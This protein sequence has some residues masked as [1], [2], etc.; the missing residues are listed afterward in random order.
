M[1]GYTEQVH[2]TSVQ[3]AGVAGAAQS[4]AVDGHT[5]DRGVP[6]GPDG[7]EVVGEPGGQDRLQRVGSTALIPRRMVA[8]LG[9][10]TCPVNGPGRAPSRGSTRRGAD[11]AEGPDR[12]RERWAGEATRTTATT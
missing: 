2:L 10:E 5:T 11:A 6:V 1:G 12:V 7:V 3:V 9:G 8:S 4:L